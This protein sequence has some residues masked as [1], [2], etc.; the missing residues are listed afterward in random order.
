V[1]YNYFNNTLAKAYNISAAKYQQSGSGFVYTET[2]SGR[3]P[4]QLRVDN[5]IFLVQSLYNS[6]NRYYELMVR[7]KPPGT[8]NG[9]TVLP[10]AVFTLQHAFVNVAAGTTGNNVGI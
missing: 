7:F 6:A 10:I 1:W 2:Y 9:V 5:P 4:T 3:Q 8:R